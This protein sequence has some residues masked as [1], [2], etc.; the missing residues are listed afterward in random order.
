MGNIKPSNIPNR[1]RNV[2]A[3]HPYVAGAVDIYDDA[4]G[5]PQSQVNQERIGNENLLQSEINALSRQNYITVSSY[6]GLPDLGAVDTI[7]RVSNW[8]GTQV[9]ATKYAEYAWNNTGIDQGEYVLLDVKTQV[10]EVYDIS[11]A[12][13]GQCYEDLTAALGTNGNNVPDGIK[14][15]GMQVK[16]I[17]G[18]APSVD[19][20]YVQYRLMAQNFTTDVTQWQGVDDD[21]IAGSDDLVKSGG[22]DNYVNACIADIGIYRLYQGMYRPDL[23]TYKQVSTRVMTSMLPNKGTVKTKSG[24]IILK[25]DVFDIYGNYISTQNVSLSGE[26]SWQSA[27]NTLIRLVFRNSADTDILPTDDII[28]YISAGFAKDIKFALSAVKPYSD[29]D[30][31]NSIV[32]ELY[33]PP[34]TVLYSSL[35]GLR[36]FKAYLSDN[37]YLTGIA[38]STGGTYLQLYNRFDTQQEALDYCNN[39]IFEY[40]GKT[41]YAV[42]DWTKLENGTRTDFPANF[43][44]YI[45]NVDL[46]PRIKEFID[47]SNCVTDNDLTVGIVSDNIANP[48]N[49]EVGR[50]VKNNGTFADLEGWAMIKVPVTAGEQI[51]VAGF[52]VARSTMPIAY[53]N[54]DTLISTGTI[55]NPNGTA[56][57]TTLTVPPGANL[58]YIDIASNDAAADYNNIQINVGTTLKDYDEYKTAITEINNIPLVGESGSTE[59][60]STIVMDLPVSDGTDIQSGYAYIDSTDRSVKVKA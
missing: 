58:V 38:Y 40:N 8:D 13:S 11:A 28:D 35:T 36:I 47:F 16:F 46:S 12:N 29:N 23:N 30:A 52:K 50:Y 56:Y 15:G 51:T 39:I 49:I 6:S 60:I 14:R 34:N 2:S 17:Q 24:F 42:L 45:N 25:Y 19:N 41:G 32:K 37:K 21:P 59:G 44:S 53:Y 1:L 43:T 9:D 26:Y 33:F 4:L 54:D 27:D 55:D 20:K 18:T 22:V 31:L 5:K 57:P 10:G 3:E 7:Y 48:D